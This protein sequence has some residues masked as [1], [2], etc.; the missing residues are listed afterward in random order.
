VTSGS[1]SPPDEPDVLVV[2][3]GPTGLVL[4]AQLHATGASVRIIDRRMAPVRES[5]ALVVQARSLEVLRALGVAEKLV[6]RGND[7]TQLCMHS[8]ARVARIKLF[9]IGIEDTAFPFLLFVSQARTEAVLN[10]HLSKSGVPVERG[11]ELVGFTPGREEVVC[12]L[13]REGWQ[14]SVRARYLVGC[15]GA[16]STVRDHAGIAFEGGD[17]PQTFVLGDVEVD[18]DLELDAVHAFP[19]PL[20]MLFF[21]PL[22]EP[23][24]W[25]MVAMRTPADGAAE[26]S[27]ESPGEPSIE[28]LQ[29][30]CDSYVGGGLRLRDPA[31]MTYFHL[32]HRQAARYREGRVLLAGDAAHVH[33]PA[34]GQGMNTGIQ[35]AWNLGWKLALVARAAA[36]EGLLDSYDEERRPVGRFVVG[37]S[38]RA[39]S[40]GTSSN[41]LVRLL[42]AGVAPRLAPLAL[43][44]RSGRALAF[45]TISQLAIHYRGSP[46]SEEGRP[47]LRRGPKAG[48]R[49]PDARIERD[50]KPIRLQEALCGPEWHLL[51]CGAPER[52]PDGPLVALCDR[53]LDQL[54][55]HKLA[56]SAAAGVLHDPTREALDRLGVGQ[57]AHYLVRPDGYIGFRAE[58]SGLVAAASYLGRVIGGRRARGPY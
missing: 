53:F 27:K 3:A 35:D 26:S 18:G 44:S 1:L 15:D 41:P 20:G 6:E 47:V 33:S 13:R 8:G 54:K 46:L 11:V 7:A 29:S 25:R 4:A 48:D 19:G 56:T 50:G 10:E 23:A 45:R 39:F 52:W 30:I 34:G 32:R 42:R 43:R 12:A 17:Y 37:F 51:L 9:D 24:T 2:G 55:V 57:A 14:G 31:W 28:T 21:F 49:L 36:G 58:G 16:N 5:R 22:G 38:D 40:I